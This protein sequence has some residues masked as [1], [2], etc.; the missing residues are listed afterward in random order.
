MYD[1][2]IDKDTLTTSELLELGFSNK[3]LAKLIEQGRLRR[4]KRGYY[5]LPNADG[6]RQHY[7]FNYK[8]NP[9]RAKLALK[10]CLEVDPEN[11]S[12]NARVLLDALN[13]GDYAQAV[14]SIGILGKQDKPIYER[15][16]NMWLLL[17][18]Y[19]V[20]LPEE[21][22]DKLRSMT[23]KDMEVHPEDLRYDDIEAENK[24]REA[25]A[26]R[27]FFLAEQLIRDT[28]PKRINEIITYKLIHLASKADRKRRNEI[29]EFT[30]DKKYM[31]LVKMLESI[32][33][34]Q[35][36]S[37]SE[38]NIYYLVCDLVS[39]LRDKVIP[40]AKQ[41]NITSMADAI[42]NHCYY[43]AR[44]LNASY[45]V[46]NELKGNKVVGILL[47]RIISEIEKLEMKKTNKAVGASSF[48][49]VTSCLMR[50]DVDGAVECLDSYLNKID[51]SQYKG[52][53]IDLIKISLL[54]KDMAFVDPMLVLSKL[55]YDDYQFDAS[56]YIQDF[57][58]SLAGKNFKK[59]AIYLDIISMSSELC[60]YSIDTTDMRKVLVSEMQSAGLTEEALEVSKP[61]PKPV[62]VKQPEKRIEIVE[63]VVEECQSLPD[64]VNSV[65]LDDNV[66]M[67]EPM[68]EN[69]ALAIV[70]CVEHVPNLKTVVIDAENGQKQIAF[71]YFNKRDGFAVD[72]GDVLRK[73]NSAYINR[74]YEDCIEL[75][76]SI[77][78][79]LE[80]PK[81][82]IYA[83]L[84]MAYYKTTYDNNFAD[85]IDYLTLAT[86][87]SKNDEGTYD[88]TELLDKMKR[89]SGYNGLKVKH[90][91]TGA[92]DN[93]KTEGVQY[94]K[95]SVPVQGN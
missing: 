31:E 75:Y 20:E 7:M 11:G 27:S 94:N 2:F 25:I 39:V 51:K 53:I 12:V 36:L 87:Q 24:V 78:H 30:A 50:Q 58:M 14:K 67:L 17:L 32:E 74:R 3:D 83:K 61:K 81:S 47:E 90:D 89:R 19:V 77:L 21:Y 49:D 42:I 26:K 37:F 33:A 45:N 6:M 64:I 86:A 85:A 40:V 23:I 66:V 34:Y 88:F 63:T 44:E 10:R 54:D 41:G 80:E 73:A 93:A 71:R 38:R 35:G 72:V 60:E 16:Y 84:G 57:Y 92:G 48:M 55:A 56:V 8:R 46:K 52:Y 95:K 79:K 76:E 18:S 69:S 70:E 13:D 91:A 65:L 62:V 5:D 28:K 68:D 4:V 29:Y 82:F 9:E 22:S 43:R 15:D 1:S 59:A